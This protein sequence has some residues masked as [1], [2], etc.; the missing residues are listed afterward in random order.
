MLALRKIQIG[1]LLGRESDASFVKDKS[2]DPENSGEGFF[3]RLLHY[4]V[5]TMIFSGLEFDELCGPG[6]R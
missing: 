4:Y 3:V 5:N 6:I 2:E 1:E